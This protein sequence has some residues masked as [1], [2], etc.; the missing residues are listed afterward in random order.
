VSAPRSSLARSPNNAPAPLP[1][2]EAWGCLC[3]PAEATRAKEKDWKGM[4]EGGQKKGKEGVMCV[5][6]SF[7]SVFF[8]FLHTPL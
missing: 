3:P 6:F 7:L 5:S 8:F 4:K 2:P 1:G